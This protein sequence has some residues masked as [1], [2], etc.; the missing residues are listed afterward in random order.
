M[1]YVIERMIGG[2]G[3]GMGGGIRSAAVG[4]VRVFCLQAGD[5][6][7]LSHSLTLG[8]H[9]FSLPIS[10][11]LLLPQSILC[12]VDSWSRCRVV[13]KV[14]KELVCVCVCLWALKT[15]AGCSSKDKQ[16]PTRSSRPHTPNPGL[17]SYS[18]RRVRSLNWPFKTG[19]PRRQEGRRRSLGRLGWEGRRLRCLPGR[20]RGSLQQRR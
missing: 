3:E 11:L 15:K 20:H 9:H 17:R 4:G 13:G 16:F 6:S 8:A 10:L 14:D 19:P 5:F 2:Q 12:R 7:V 1:V 18:L